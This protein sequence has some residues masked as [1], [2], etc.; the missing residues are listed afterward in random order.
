MDNVDAWLLFLSF[1][2]SFKNAAPVP[3]GGH[4]Q[5]IDR[6]LLARAAAILLATDHESGFDDDC[7]EGCYAHDDHDQEC[8]HKPVYEGE[9]GRW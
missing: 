1:V 9:R 4:P 7:D 5:P 6:Q 2:L 8:D 3:P